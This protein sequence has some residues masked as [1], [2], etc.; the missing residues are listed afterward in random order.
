MSIDIGTGLEASLH[1][2][3]ETFLPTPVVRIPLERVTL[4]ADVWENTPDLAPG[5]VGVY[6]TLVVGRSERCV[7]NEQW[8][9][10]LVD[11][12]GA[13]VPT[14]TTCGQNAGQY[15]YSRI[16]RLPR[17][18]LVGLRLCALHYTPPRTPRR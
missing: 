2:P 8:A 17:A 9:L 12:H 3:R 7:P 10:T 16:A 6:L 4:W 14:T 13:P 5:H 1:T 11:E 15:L 18:A